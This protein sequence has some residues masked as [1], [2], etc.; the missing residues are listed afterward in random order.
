MS[1]HPSADQPTTL[2]HERGASWYWVLLGPVSALALLWIESSSG[3]GFQPLVPALFLVLVTGF[4][5]I[6]VKA[7]RTHTSV[8][9][10]DR[11]LRQGTETIRLANI[12][13]V[14]PEPP[15]PSRSEEKREPWQTARALGEL[16][17]VPRG[18][19]GIGLRLAGGRTVQAWA[20][21]YRHLRVA[22]TPLI[23]ERA[24]IEFDDGDD[25][26]EPRS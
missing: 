14:Y 11:T 9:L 23:E 4:I 19:K 10:T 15:P 3:Y 20:R 26:A 2:F 25:T 8:E 12:V 7:A 5:A 21:R 16:T 17:G 18:R 6:Q 24:G 13:K 1:T 22:L